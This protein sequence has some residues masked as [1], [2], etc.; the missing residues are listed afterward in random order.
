MNLTT[1]LATALLLLT[2]AAYA[3]NQ[4]VSVCEQGGPG[5]FPL[6]LNRRSASLL[7]EPGADSAVQLAANNFARG[8]ER[9]S[10]QAPRRIS[11]L[12]EAQGNLI[13]AGSDRRGA[14]YGLYDLSEKIGVSPWHWFADVPVARKNNLYVAAA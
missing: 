2:P 9:I 4:P 14:V 6:V 12:A 1:R 5:S 10:G 13:I 7:V 8:L 11:S 3:C